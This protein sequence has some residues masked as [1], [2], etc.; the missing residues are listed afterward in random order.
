MATYNA[1][2]ESKLGGGKKG[3]LDFE[4]SED[5]NMFM[6]TARDFGKNEIKP[7]VEEHEKKEKF[8]EGFFR[9]SINSS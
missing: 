4:L 2:K 5:Q 3:P 9:G 8:S 6:D 7:L 1:I